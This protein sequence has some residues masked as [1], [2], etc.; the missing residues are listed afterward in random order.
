MAKKPVDLSVGWRSFSSD[1]RKSSAGGKSSPAPVPIQKPEPGKQS[2]YDPGK[3]LGK[4]L[5]KSKA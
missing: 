1:L 2:S 5:H 4:Y 3:N